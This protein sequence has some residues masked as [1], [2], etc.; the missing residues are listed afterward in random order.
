[1]IVILLIK[2][3]SCYYFSGCSVNTKN[4]LYDTKE[5]NII[6]TQQINK[7]L[8]ERILIEKL[9]KLTLLFKLSYLHVIKKTKYFYIVFYLKLKDLLSLFI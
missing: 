7:N 1:M 4:H 5:N 2:F 8:W 6:N 9:H 3:L